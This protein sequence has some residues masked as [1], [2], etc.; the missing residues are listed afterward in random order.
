VLPYWI[1]KDEPKKYAKG[2]RWTYR[3]L[4]LISRRGLVIGMLDWGLKVRYM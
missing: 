4:E 2:F 1:I 3:K